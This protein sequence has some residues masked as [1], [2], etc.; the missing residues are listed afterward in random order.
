MTA[1]SNP[2]AVPAS[3]ADEDMPPSDQA[4][5]VLD[6]LLQQSGENVRPSILVVDDTPA[7][8]VV[9]ERLL[10]K[11]EA[12]IV[13]A[14]SGN[15][16]LSLTLD[17]D[18][19]LIL[20]DVQM[21]D[22]DGFEVAEMLRQEE[23]TA[24]I[25]IIF[26]TAAFKDVFSEERGYGAGA[27][28]Y[29]TKPVNEKILLSKVGLFVDLY[30]RKRALEVAMVELSRQNRRLADEIA[31]RRKAEDR[32]RYQA[33]HDMLTDLPNRAKLF[34]DLKGQINRPSAVGAHA[35]LLYIDLDGFKPVN[36]R[37]GHHAGDELLKQISDRLRATVATPGMPSRLGG[38]EFAVLLPSVADADDAMARAETVR[39]A[40]A[41]PYA[42]Y[43][44]GL[45][46]AVEITIGASIGVALYPDHGGDSDAVVAAADGAMYIAKKAG[47][48]RV[49]LYAFE[50]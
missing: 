28:D 29:I 2:S 6:R 12:D 34:E 49:V 19:A 15:E 20:L 5:P 45:A 35:A 7:N 33:S 50:D 39:A 31:E 27:I 41:A 18:F 25:P 13:L 48:N 43:V 9:M 40:I 26:V 36:D 32:L 47:K 10:A 24:D 14:E 44:A 4:A 11:V 30:T 37:Y 38:D 16:A 46:A 3:G 21:P 8:L 22:M 17:H 42:L 1:P 23:T